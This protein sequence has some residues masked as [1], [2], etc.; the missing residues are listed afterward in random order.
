MRVLLFQAPV[1]IRSPHAHLSP[2][3]G[4]AYVAQF[5]IDQGHEVDL[6]DLNLTGLNPLRITATLNRA[7]PDLVGIS[8]HTETY[9]N[10]LA[11]A[12]LV[13]EHDPSIPVLFGGPHTSIL[14]LEV[15][16]EPAVDYVAIGE[17]EQTAAQ[18]VRALE[19]GAD[20]AALVRIPGLGHKGDGTAVLNEPREPLDAAD[21]GR[22]AR[23]LLSL[24]FYEDAHNVLAARGG[25][26]YRCPFCS[27][28]HLWGGLRRMRP[29]ADVL[30][31]VADVIRD[32]GAQHVF[33]VDDILTLDRT[34]LAE[35]MDAIEERGGFTWGCA[36]R[37]DRVD[38]A[39]LHRMAQTGCTGIQF[40]IESGAQDILDSVKGIQKEDALDAVRSAVDAGIAVACS[41]MIPF[42]DDTEETLAQTAAFMADIREAGG[43]LLISYTTPFPGTKFY[44]RAEELGLTIL[45]RDWSLYDCKHMVMETRNFSAE[46]IEALAENIANG[47]GLSQTE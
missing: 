46:R 1:S 11:I 27:A 44:E 40:G 5:L 17:G 12:A 24:E 39:M 3:L 32:Y 36:T 42:P 30:D 35:L 7:R 43:K 31:E 4:L 28:S 19:N 33:F 14:P 25:C 22:P 16:A 15:L 21:I 23:Q 13:K 45:T 41:F 6:V 34:W 9:P 38:D 20:S 8:S 29:V 10:A 2:P 18:L 37:V 47:L 26:P